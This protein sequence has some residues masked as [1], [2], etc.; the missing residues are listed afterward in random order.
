VIT[1]Q[2]RSENLQDVPIAV[3]AL[4]ADALERNDIATSAASRC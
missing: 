4:T 2:R 3:T 1:A